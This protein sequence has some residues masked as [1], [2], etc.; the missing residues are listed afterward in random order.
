MITNFGKI[1]RKLR[2]D[3]GEIL[4]DMAEKLGVSPSFLSAV[5]VGRKSAPSGWARL[6]A[7]EYNLS[8]VQ[9]EELE[10]AA[11]ETIATVRIDCTK[12]D[13]KQRSA[14]LVFARAF[15]SMPEDTAEQIIKLLN[16]STT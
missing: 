4:M 6:I 9:Y 15:N 1:L 11:K 5:E 3:R 7:D 13:A 16:R 8:P 14:A 2:I 12:A 10:A